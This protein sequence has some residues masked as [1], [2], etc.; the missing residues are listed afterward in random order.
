MLSLEV[1]GQVDLEQEAD[2]P[3]FTRNKIMEARAKAIQNGNVE[4]L[5]SGALDDPAEGKKAS[6]WRDGRKRKNP[7]R[8]QHSELY[9]AL[10]KELVGTATESS[11]PAA[12]KKQASPSKRK[13][14]PS[15]AATT[16]SASCS[17]KAEQDDDGDKKP[18]A[19]DAETAPNKSLVL[20]SGLDV[21]TLPENMK[22]LY[23]R[24]KQ[25]K[26]LVLPDYYT[27]EE[28]Q[29]SHVPTQSKISLEEFKQDL[30]ESVDLEIENMFRTEEEE[31]QK[32]IIFNKLNKDYLEQ[33]QRKESDRLTAEATNK[34]LEEEDL[35]Q[36]QGRSRY[37][38]KRGSAG[39]ANMTT[40]EQL[41][42]AMATRKVSRKINYDAMSH[43]FDDDGSFAL[44]GGSGGDAV[45][46]DSEFDLM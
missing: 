12:A 28:L 33:Q 35:V 24:N 18:A 36:A 7:N 45:T 27:E 9:S 10:E 2:P 17:D 46:G 16:D 30:P 19:K 6:M 37:K 15:E 38:T 14:P 40:E 42:A 5:T 44:D 29:A 11:N 43:I 1:F 8:E 4:L 23:P 3:V 31:K 21:S 22:P 39:D 34:A 25:G 13:Q 41:L 26:A 32:E 20:Y